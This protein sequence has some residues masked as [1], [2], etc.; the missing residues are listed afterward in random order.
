MSKTWSTLELQSVPGHR[1]R[2]IHQLVVALF[3]QEVGEINLTPVQFSALQTICTQPSIDQKT[4]A[5]TI[6]YD[7]ATT[8]GVIDRLEARGLVVRKV[9]PNDRRARQITPTER[10]L[11]TLKAAVPRVLKSQSLFL[12]P[13]TKAERREF[14]RLLKVLID[15]NAEL[16][17]I[18]AKQ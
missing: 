12:A 6:G 7:A 15:A 4:L 9:A 16:S 1:V 13:L 14:M 5:R 3:M 11:Q 17:N 8:G 18:P 10:G 2:R